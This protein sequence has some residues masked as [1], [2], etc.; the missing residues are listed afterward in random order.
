MELVVIAG[1]TGLGAD[2]SSA[3]RALG[4]P[5]SN[6]DPTMATAPIQIRAL[7]REPGAERGLRSTFARWPITLPIGQGYPGAIEGPVRRW[8]PKISRPG[9]CKAALGGRGIPPALGA[10]RG[11]VVHRCYKQAN[12]G[13]AKRGVERKSARGARGEWAGDRG[14]LPN[15][16]RR[17]RAA[18]ERSPR[19]AGIWPGSSWRRQISPCPS[20]AKARV[21][22]RKRGAD[23]GEELLGALSTRG[24]VES[25]LCGGPL[26]GATVAPGC[27]RS[28]EERDE[29]AEET[30]ASAQAGHGCRSDR[31][32]TTLAIAVHSWRCWRRP[33]LAGWC[34]GGDLWGEDSDRHREELCL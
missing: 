16:V 11:P 23:A 27:V 21:G 8:G 26:A 10:D 32:G 25:K 12:F 6:S 7:K 28:K 3:A 15:P 33:H 1:S 18:E 2:H 9:P 13:A 34:D 30:P 20:S 24:E 31:G 14:S 29:T 19:A 5:L 4:D 17:R 22:R